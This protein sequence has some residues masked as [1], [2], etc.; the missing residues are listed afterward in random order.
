MTDQIFLGNT[1]LEISCPSEVLKKDQIYNRFQR[2]VLP[3]KK[4]FFISFL[5]VEQIEMPEG[6]YTNVKPDLCIVKEISGAE[7]RLYYRITAD[8]NILYARSRLADGNVTVWYVQGL[9]NWTGIVNAFWAHIHLES[10]LLQGEGL[11]LHSVCYQYQN[12]AIVFSAPSGTGKTTHASLWKTYVG[13]KIVN[14]D[15]TLLQRQEG[16][17]YACGFPIHGSASECENESMPLNTI[18]ILRQARVNNVI[19]LSMAQKVKYLYS[20]SSVNSWNEAAVNQALELIV[21]LARSV[22]IVML[23]CTKEPAAAHYL[24]DYLFPGES[25][26]TV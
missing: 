1:R 26:G 9:F 3:T 17:W 25:Y 14:G 2:S 24:H 5:P 19:E 22:R 15:R 6:K 7:N 8:G 21:D 12:S 4:K 10:L 11:I 18:V 16:K 13:G 23:E 20:E